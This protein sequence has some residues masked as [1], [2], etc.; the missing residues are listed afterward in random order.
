MKVWVWSHLPKKSLKENFIVSAVT[1]RNLMRKAQE[2]LKL[3]L[4]V[5]CDPS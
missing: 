3:G 4:V 1:K 2:A 5:E